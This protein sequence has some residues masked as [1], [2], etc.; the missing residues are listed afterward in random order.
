MRTKNAKT[1]CTGKTTM[2]RR[3]AISLALMA[4]TLLLTGASFA[5]LIDSFIVFGPGTSGS[6]S[7]TGTSITFNVSGPAS[8]P[9]L[10]LT[11]G[12]FTMAASGLAI[13]S[14]ND[15]GEVD[16]FG[17]PNTGTFTVTIGGDTLAGS[18]NMGFSQ[19]IN[20]QHTFFEGTLTITTSTPGFSNAYP[21]NSVADLN[22]VTDNRGGTTFLSSGEVDPII[23]EP[24]TLILMGSGLLGMA[25]IV[26]R[27]L[28]SP[29]LDQ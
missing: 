12:K 27:K 1:I 4:L 20:S 23:P 10:P 7:I 28:R 17:Q 14:H 9:L 29:D 26:R 15:E 11:L 16:V 18:L 24:R 6:F 13:S 19:M 5:S 22:F 25:G 21:V 8:S 2:A 3:L